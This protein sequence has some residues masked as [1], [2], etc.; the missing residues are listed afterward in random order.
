MLQKEI[1][2]PNISPFSSHVLLVKKNDGSWCLYM[3]YRALNAITI[4]D[5]FP[6]PTIDELLDELGGSSWFS[7]LDL[8]QG[9]H[10]KDICKTAFRTH[11]GHFKFWVMSFGLCNAP[12][13]FQ[14]TMNTI[15]RPYLRR[16]IIVFFDYIL[17]YSR[18][19]EDHLSHSDKA[20]QILLEGKFIFKFVKCSFAQAQVEYLCHIVLSKGVE[21]MSSKI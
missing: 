21:P 20:F 14:D 2:R 10:Q 5:R 11:H 9:Y 15:F 1:I 17:I 19:F 12:S 4:K 8:F 13:L 18:T 16:F 7:K 3:D 6:I